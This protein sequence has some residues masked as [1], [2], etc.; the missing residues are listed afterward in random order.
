MEIIPILSAISLKDLEA[1]VALG[2]QLAPH[3]RPGDCVALYG[4]LGAGKTALARTI[5][6]ALGVNEAVPSPTFTLVQTYET[7]TL[8]LSHYDLY[9]LESPEE[10]REL[11]LDEALSDGVA[12]I[13]W[14]DR[15]GPYLPEDALNIT[16]TNVAGSEQGRLVTI[17]G[18][19]RWAVLTK[20]I[21]V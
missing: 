4:D 12:L 21:H 20:E 6:Q 1:T 10:V 2:R 7:E 19:A 15:A 9:R 17:T 8:L 5:L 16:L 13:E 11:G 14:P 18:P 3:L